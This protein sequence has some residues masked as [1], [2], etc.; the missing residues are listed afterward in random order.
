MMPSTDQSTYA[1]VRKTI[2]VHATPE[3]AFEVF[4]AEIDS[5]WPRSHHIGS[6]PMARVLIERRVG[7][8]CYTEHVD[9]TRS[10]WGRV[11]SWDPPRRLVIAWQITGQWKHE[12]DLNKSSEVEVGFTAVGD[13]HTRV[14]LEHR[15]LE[16][17][18][19]DAGAMRAAVDGSNGWS[20][21]LKLYE[22]RLAAGMS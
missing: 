3:R 18:G 2:T 15:H 11:L 16:R 14:D 1:P 5:W 17:H 21:L 6:A 8:R 20:G 9:G 12:P 22:T 19:A 7:G 4:T 13:G 10:D